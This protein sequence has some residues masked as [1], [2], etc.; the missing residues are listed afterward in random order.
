[1]PETPFDETL[2]RIL[3]YPKAPDGAQDDG[4]VVDVMARVRRERRRRRTILLAF[5]GIGALF[6]LAG[7]TLLADPIG[8]LLAVETLSATTL[9]QGA[10][11]TCGAVA[12]YVWVMGDDLTLQR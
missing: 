11:L 9:M 4:F 6:G 2:E 5:G 10:L 7:A 8:R 12:F 1:V 3:A